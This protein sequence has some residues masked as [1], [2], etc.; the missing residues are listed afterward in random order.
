MTVPIDTVLNVDPVIERLR[1]L[2]RESPDLKDAAQIYEMILPLIRDADLKVGPVSITAD[3]VRAKMEKGVHILNDIDLDL[4]VRAISE[5]MLRLACAIERASEKSG[6]VPRLNAARQIRIA[7]EENMLDINGLLPHVASGERGPVTAAAKELH[8][9]PDLAWALSLNAI[10]PA[11]H[12]WRRQLAPMTA[13]IQWDKGSCFICGA[14]A[15]LG[16]LQ[17]DV[18][19]RHLRCGQCGADWRVHRLHC[20][21]CGN[22]DHNSLG[23]IQAEAGNEKVRVEVC[24]NCRGYIKVIATFA[25]TP[26]EMLPV[27]D[28]ATLHLDYIAKERGYIK[29]P[30]PE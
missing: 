24:D 14:A 15:T 2:A 20:I 12:A 21:Y 3:D 25:P 23:Y 13:E 26:P 4:D 16:E 6:I 18:Q 17:G 11:L 29:H 5:L 7:I 1:L 8:L 30:A 19:A 9:D 22:E 10:R 28:L 27:E